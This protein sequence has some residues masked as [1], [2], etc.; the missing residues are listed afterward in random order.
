MSTE[1]GPTIVRFLLMALLAG[2]QYLLGALSTL[3]YVSWVILASLFLLS[4]ALRA[5]KPKP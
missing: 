3:G 4:S 5:T 1:Q 2:V